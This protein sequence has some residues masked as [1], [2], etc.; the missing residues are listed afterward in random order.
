MTWPF[1]YQ[2]ASIEFERFMIDARDF[3]DLATTNMAWNMVVGVLWAFRYRLN[4]QEGLRFANLLPPVLRALFIED[5]DTSEPVKSFASN[6]ELMKDVRSIRTVHNFAPPNAIQAVAQA[7]LKHV[8]RSELERVLLTLPI[9]AS[10][11]WLDSATKS[12]RK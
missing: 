9:G 11:F 5:W 3:A 1:E 7:L 10:E 4:M 2:N 12:A 8:D 6:E